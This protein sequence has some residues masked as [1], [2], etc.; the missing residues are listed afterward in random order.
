[1]PIVGWI[2][3]TNVT[4]KWDPVP[5]K[6][7]AVAGDIA[8]TADRW[9][10]CSDADDTSIPGDTASE[11]GEDAEDTAVAETLRQQR[12]APMTP[13][14]TNQ[15]RPPSS[16]NNKEKEVGNFGLYFGNWGERGFVEKGEVARIRRQKH[17][18]QILKSLGQVVILAEAGLAIEDMLKQPPV[19]GHSG[20][21]S[22]E[23]RSTK[24]HFVV[25]GN[26]KSALLIASRTDVTSSL[27]CL[28]SEVHEDHPYKEKGKPKM[29]RSRFLVCEIVFKQN[30]GHIGKEIVVCGVHGHY[31]T[32]KKEWP[33]PWGKFWNMLAECGNLWH[34]VLG[35]RLQY[36]FN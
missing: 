1:M 11:A 34:S 14:H 25:R 5:S 30:I 10:S 20:S 19:E 24:E 4:C 7:T 35:W 8:R 28:K 17:D 16:T 12:R 2:Q 27:V 21:G 23:A 18:R 6:D 22:L 36:V 26:E 29:A 33:Q 32:M 13:N 15:E 31:R 3:P 9:C